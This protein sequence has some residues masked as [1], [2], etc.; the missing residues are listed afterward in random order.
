[1]Y[2]ILIMDQKTIDS[3]VQYRPLF[4]DA[5]KSGVLGICKWNERGTTIDNALPEIRSLTNDKEDWRAIIVRS[6]VDANPSCPCDPVNPYDYMENKDFSEQLDDSEVPLIRLTQMLGGIPPL[7][8]N[9][10]LQP[11]KPKNKEEEKYALPKYIYVPKE[12]SEKQAKHEL[13]SSKYKFD[14]HTPSSII[15]I[16]LRIKPE[17]NVVERAWEDKS[18]IRESRSSDFWRRNHYP[19]IC[20]FLVYDVQELGPVQFEADIYDFWLSVVMVSINDMRSDVLQA[21]RLYTIR[22]RLDIELMTSFFQS[23]AARMSHIRL[24][25]YKSIENEQEMRMSEDPELPGYRREAAVNVKFP[26]TDDYSV[27]DSSFHMFSANPQKDLANWE[28]QKKA[29]EDK[30]VRTMKVV[31]RALDQTA[32]RTRPFD[33]YED[34]QVKVLTPYQNEDMNN[35]VNS[36]FRQIIL[37]Q[38]ILPDVDIVNGRKIKKRAESVRDYLKGRTMKE[39]AMMV[40]VGV[41]I[42]LL[43]SVIPGIIDYYNNLTDNIDIGIYGVGIELSI[44]LLFAFGTLLIQKL[45]LNSLIDSYNDQLTMAFSKLITCADDYSTYMGNILSH[46]RGKSYIEH[47]DHKILVTGQKEDSKY[48]HLKAVDVIISK[49]RAISKAY[50]MDI[51][52]DTKV[53]YRDVLIDYDTDPSDNKLYAFD[54]DGEYSAELNSSGQHV[55]APFEFIT[56]VDIKR[57]ELY[58]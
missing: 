57:E 13:L 16:T 27:K 9:F 30:L 42:C 28:S 35:E 37:D 7:E 19:S 36:L 3:F 54:G 12:D 31:E 5:I 34:Y 33:S 23:Y 18:E 25:T 49:L 32:V 56:G 8:I 10:E 51:N 48:K 41:L 44:V 47:S 4:F 2:S 15:C 14:G 40:L 43:M 52:F 22:S 24:A 38:S 50:H 26:K 55:S 6:Y 39:P 29:A 53:Q 17:V 45:K 58:G 11:Q 46:S 21:Y 1:M 20:R